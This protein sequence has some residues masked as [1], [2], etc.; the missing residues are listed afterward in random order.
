MAHK[1]AQRRD[2]GGLAQQ[3]GLQQQET[4]DALDQL[5]R[6]G[7]VRRWPDGQWGLTTT[8]NSLR[9]RRTA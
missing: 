1:Y 9:N 4:Q 2:V 7:L 6:R 5:Q 3:L 8:G